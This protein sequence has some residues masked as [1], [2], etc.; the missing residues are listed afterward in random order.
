M[1]T[2][3]HADTTRRSALWADR[4]C[5][6]RVRR[7]GLVVLRSAP[8]AAR[9]DVL[10]PVALSEPRPPTARQRS[11]R[12]DSPAV[13]VWSHRYPRIDPPR[14]VAGTHGR[15]VCP[16]GGGGDR[17]GI[18]GPGGDADRCRPT[19]RGRPA[20]QY[21][22]TRGRFEPRD[23]PNLFCCRAFDRPAI[24]IVPARWSDPA[25]ATR[26]ERLWA[27]AS[28]TDREPDGSDPPGSR[29]RDLGR[30]DGSMTGY[31]YRH[32]NPLRHKPLPNR[33]YCGGRSRFR[34][35]RAARRTHAR[36]ARRKCGNRPCS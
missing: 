24:R 4:R 28:A 33:R 16:T 27:G 35:W 20:E 1:P 6:R 5:P 14:N 32:R 7:R 19:A 31:R 26:R 36:A 3:H 9:R 25:E 15:V 2:P 8:A 13:R 23:R 30:T 22:P 12:A 17:T 10:R 29:L 18:A 34:S 21:S 11:L